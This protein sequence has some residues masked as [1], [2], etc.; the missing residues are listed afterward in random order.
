VWLADPEGC[1]ALRATVGVDSD[2]RP[3]GSFGDDEMIR[4]IRNFPLI[5]LVA[6]PGVGLDHVMVRELVE[7]LTEGSA[8]RQS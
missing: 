7:R 4:V 8:A 1:A 6:F 2:G 5:A 3:C